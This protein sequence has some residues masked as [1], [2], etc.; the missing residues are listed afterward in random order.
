MA[1]QIR[2]KFKN[3]KDSDVVFFEGVALPLEAL[4]AA[5]VDKKGLAESGV[6]LIV[7]DAAS[8]A[9]AG[10]PPR[11]ARSAPFRRT[12]AEPSQPPP[13]A[14]RAAGT[15]FG[16]GATIPKNASVTVRIRPPP[17]SRMG[18]GFGGG[19]ALVARTAAGVATAR[20][21][22]MCV[23]RSRRVRQAERADSHGCWLPWWR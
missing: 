9:C 12:E 2:F 7:A 21:G 15:E 6:D 13:P 5:I 16:H 4:K 3:A 11:A 18:G 10:R 22:T 19:A 23:A 1:S 8:G 14:R 17:A 20:P